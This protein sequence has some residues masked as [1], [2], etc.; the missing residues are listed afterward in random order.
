MVGTPVSF[1]VHNLIVLV[2]LAIWLCTRLVHMFSAPVGYLFRPYIV[3]RSRDTARSR[4]R[5]ARVWESRNPSRRERPNSQRVCLSRIRL[6]RRPCASS[7]HR[8]RRSLEH[9]HG[10]G[11]V[12]LVVPSDSR[13]SEARRSGALP[14]LAR[15]GGPGSVA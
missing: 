14:C 9:P 4:L 10:T 5:Y 2:L 8:I 7:P 15:T 6:R 11:Q 13:R 3:Y 1:Q 12:G